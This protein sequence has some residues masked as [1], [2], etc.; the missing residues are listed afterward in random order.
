[1]RY[2]LARVT[3]HHLPGGRIFPLNVLNAVKACPEVCSIY[4]ATANPAM[5]LVADAGK[6]RAILGVV[7]G[8]SPH[9]IEGEGDIQWRM[10]FLRKIGY[11]K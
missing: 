7:D 8:E 1:M 11:K 4:C 5:V 3:L 10:D 6:G 9:G 2:P